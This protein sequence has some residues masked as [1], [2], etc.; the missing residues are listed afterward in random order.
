[1]QDEAR[2]QLGKAFWT[3]SIAIGNDTL[4]KCLGSAWEPQN[5]HELKNYQGS[6]AL[7]KA[8]EPLFDDIADRKR[9]LFVDEFLVDAPSIAGTV[10][11]N[12]QLV[13]EIPQHISWETEGKAF[14]LDLEGTG[15]FPAICRIFWYVHSNGSLSYHLSL[16][17][18]YAHDARHYYTLSLIQKLV[19]EKEG[20]QWARERGIVCRADERRQRFWDFVIEK[21]NEQAMDLFAKLGVE[22]CGDWWDRFFSRGAGQAP[23]LPDRR[24]L[25]VLKDPYFF[26]LLSPAARNGISDFESLTTSGLSSNRFP[27]SALNAVDPVKLD[28]Y[29]LSGF[30]QNIIDF[31]R[32]D[33][34]EVRDGTDPIYPLAESGEA[35]DHF[36]LYATPN[37]IVEVVS[38]SRSLETGHEHIGTCPYIFL[39]HLMTFH[40]E[41]LSKLFEQKLSQLLERLS[42]SGLNSSQFLA[43]GDSGS[44]A[45]LSEFLEFRL[46]VFEEVQKHTLFNVFRYDTERA[47]YDQVERVRGTVPRREYWEQVLGRLEKTLEDVRSKIR[48]ESEDVRQE[49]DNRL[50][51]RLAIVTFFSVAQ[52][53]FQS[54]DAI[55]KLIG[56]TEQSRPFISGGFLDFLPDYLDA[57]LLILVSIL[58]TVLLVYEL[59]VRWRK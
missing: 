56:K 8:I 16:E 25:V 35:P 28:Y 5:R 58:I 23:Q 6:S 3:L 53:L 34:S 2:A 41:S 7:S 47:F 1:V 15:E 45:A 27:V 49:S 9:H 40:N 54:S 22:R 32:Q 52:A 30:F 14:E 39:V 10:N 50:N 4:Q 44:K 24:I 18:D 51:R 48:Q 20:T 42:A 19:F 33:T 59:A 36:V 13:L 55:R 43:M 46:K 11:I 29:F 31:L 57:G 26:D 21:F 12:E 38:R 37:S 17:L